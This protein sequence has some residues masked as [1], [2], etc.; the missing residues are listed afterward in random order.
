MNRW[1]FRNRTFFLVSVAIFFSS[2]ALIRAERFGGFSSL[3][4][5][6]CLQDSVC[7]ARLNSHVI[8]EHA[9]VFPTGGY[10]GQFYYYVAAGLYGNQD[11]LDLSSALKDSPGSG[12]IFVDSLGFRIPRIGFP[13]LSGWL[14]LFGASALSF[15]MPVLLLLS[16]LLSCWFLFRMR[17]SAAWLYG[18]N[19]VSLLSFGLNLAEPLAMSLAIFA[20]IA[21]IRPGGMTGS[22][23]NAFRWWSALLALFLALISKETMFV[24]GVAL[25]W[26]FLLS[27]WNRSAAMGTGIKQLMSPPGPVDPAGVGRQKDRSGAVAGLYAIASYWSLPFW[28]FLAGLAALI[29][30]YIAGFFSGESAAGKLQIPFLGLMDFLRSGQGLSG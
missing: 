26:L 28:I 16:H 13:L 30:Y 9:A 10:D 15:G 4:G 21:M 27:A 8:P 23:G 29:W 18:F 3:I 5:F 2:Y 20:S 7:F 12:R 22:A 17:P 1:V 11:I 6:G 19:P 25:G 24:P 14:F